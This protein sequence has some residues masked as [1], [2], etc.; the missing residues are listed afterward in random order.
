LHDGDVEKIFAICAP[1]NYEVLIR[2]EL[3]GEGSS[4]NQRIAEDNVNVLYIMGC[5]E[6]D[7][8]VI[9]K[10]LASIDT[11]VAAGVTSWTQEGVDIHVTNKNATKEH[12]I[13]KLLELLNIPKEDSIGVGDANN[14]IHLFK[15]VGHKVAM[16]NATE[17]LKS[18]ADE[19]CASVDEDGLADLIR[20]YTQ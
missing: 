9:L 19:I 17:L 1:Y 4:A 6:T 20:S 8:Q 14:D 5:S 13:T 16:G 18:Q 12:A 10:Q 7:S 11:I 2:N 3:I 15:A